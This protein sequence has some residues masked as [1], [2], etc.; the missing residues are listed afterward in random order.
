MKISIIIITFYILLLISCI[1]FP[2]SNNLKNNCCSFYDSLYKRNLCLVA[3]KMP[4]FREEYPILYFIKNYKEPKNHDIYSYST[5]ISFVIEKDGKIYNIKVLS[6]S[7][8][9]K[10]KLQEIDS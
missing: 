10:N 9:E 3:A 6:N 1:Y 5:I 2:K 4:K 7:K 8:N